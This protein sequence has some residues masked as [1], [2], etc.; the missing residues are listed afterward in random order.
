MPFA[1]KET[2]FS[3]KNTKPIH[4]S[5]GYRYS[6]TTIDPELLQKICT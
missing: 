1:G 2:S 6:F 4:R 5:D 3:P